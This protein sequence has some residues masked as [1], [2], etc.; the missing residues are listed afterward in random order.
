ML[1]RILKIVALNLLLGVVLCTSAHAKATETALMR[2]KNDTGRLIS[3]VCI[4]GR[5]AEKFL[6]FN[7]VDWTGNK[8]WKDVPAGTTTDTFTVKYNYGFLTTGQ[9]YWYVYALK[10]DGSGF[11]P[12]WNDRTL[13]P[14]DDIADWKQCSLSKDDKGMTATISINSTGIMHVGLPG[15]S[16][17]HEELASIS[18]SGNDITKA[19]LT[20]YGYA[21]PHDLIPDPSPTQAA[22]YAWQLFISSMQATDATSTS[23]AGREVPS[24][25]YNFLQTGEKSTFT[26]PL[27][28][29]SLYHRTEAYPYY[30]KGASAPN[31]INQVPVY[32]TY[33][34][35]SSKTTMPFVPKTK[36]Y[37]F[38]DETNQIGQNMLYY[39]DSNDSSFPVLYMAKVNEIETL[40]ALGL[41]QYQNRPSVPSNSNSWKFPNGMLEVKTAWRR[42]SDIRN[43][44]P[45]DYHISQASYLVGR[46]GDL[47]PRIVTDQF[48]LIGIH[49]IQ[50][51]ANHPELIFSTFEHVNATTRDSSGAITDPSFTLSYDT[52]AYGT[53]NSLTAHALGAYSI[54]AESQ[55][56]KRNVITKYQLPSQVT[57][58]RIVDQPNTI[59]SEVNGVNNKV[60]A[61]ITSASP[62]SVWGNY[63]LKGV[64]TTPTSDETTNDFFLANIVIESSRPGVQLFKGGVSPPGNNTLTNTRN[65]GNISVK[66]TESKKV[67][68]PDFNMG[69]C[70]GC[71]GN[72]QQAGR[73]FSFVAFG[74]GGKGNGA[75]LVAPRSLKGSALQLHNQQ[76]MSNRNWFSQ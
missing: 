25:N 56:S 52:L 30:D 50:K 33:L 22:N 28:F 5:Y 24:K 53:N 43:S 37:V 39:L 11:A 40:Y 46:A 16:D 45:N 7:G 60:G 67:P 49:I 38:L 29:E 66:L 35:T 26:N 51:T 44:D 1:T 34:E 13:P 10:D 65:A 72:A 55:P 14:A 17:C 3:K 74:A 41:G 2:F 6:P 68:Q 75:D 20:T 69:G 62:L 32:R 48:A 31:P 12:R 47:N 4:Y 36:D 63:R 9:S 18:N 27:V 70:K 64:Q 42:V 71:H 8:C 21:V 61:L 73:D 59:S 15:S 58:T 76:V 54:N 23:G 57:K 19:D